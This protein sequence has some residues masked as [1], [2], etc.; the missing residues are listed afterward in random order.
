M[1]EKR[2][3]ITEKEEQLEIILAAFE[4]VRSSGKY[5]MYMDGVKI[6]SSIYAILALWRQVGA[7]SFFKE[8]INKDYFF[9]AYAKRID[10]GG[11]ERLTEIG[12]V[13]PGGKLHKKPETF[14]FFK[15][16]YRFIEDDRSRISWQ[17]NLL[18]K[19]RESARAMG[20]KM[21]DVWSISSLEGVM[22]ED[23]LIRSGAQILVN[24]PVEKEFC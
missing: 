6:L 12:E 11:Q 4:I 13:M 21:R 3:P 18:I 19:A 24:D 16:D 8:Y 17:I 9:T 2:L 10:E 1:E 14:Q 5:N 7:H 22:D 20:A 23:I 15:P